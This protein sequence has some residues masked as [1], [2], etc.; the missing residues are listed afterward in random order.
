M[1]AQERDWYNEK[2]D[3]G[4]Y[5]VQEPLESKHSSGINYFKLYL[6]IVAG[7]ISAY[8]IM[9]LLAVMFS[10]A[11]LGSFFSSF[12]STPSKPQKQTQHSP[13]LQTDLYDLAKKKSHEV[14]QQIAKPQI[15]RAQ[16]LNRQAQQQAAANKTNVQTCEFWRNQDQ[17][18]K[19]DRNKMHTNSACERAYGKL[20]NRIN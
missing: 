15:D 6:T 1:G 9:W 5:R 12:E 19:T 14:A 18:E 3:P 8:A 2:R 10:V 7:I 16:E 11:L 4:E 13:A 20:W 17:A